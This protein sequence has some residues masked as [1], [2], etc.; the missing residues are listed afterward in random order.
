MKSQVTPGILK[1]F[2][3][4]AG[5]FQQTFHTPLDRLPVFVAALLAGSP[6]TTA[7]AVTLKAIGSTPHHLPRL[8][9]TYDLPQELLPELTITAT[10]AQEV[11]ALLVAALSD[12]LDFYFLPK[13]NRFLIYADHD[14]F[15]TIFSARKTAVSRIAAAM[16]V[17][18]VADV[19]GFS[20]HT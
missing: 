17:A 9:A 10:G 1:R 20:R 15:T 2:H 12:W 11:Q 7:G 8:L 19:P 5:K 14:E 13:P 6:P 3:R 18:G 16:A 4:P